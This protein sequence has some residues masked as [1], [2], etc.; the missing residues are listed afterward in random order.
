M[1]VMMKRARCFTIMIVP[2]SEEATYSL[3]L[4]LGW[5]N[6]GGDIRYRL[7]RICILFVYRNVA[8]EAREARIPPD[9]PVQ[10]EEINAFAYETQKLSR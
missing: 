9:K 8:Q 4:P 6:A 3:R 10:Q 2:H 5:S 7:D 1:G